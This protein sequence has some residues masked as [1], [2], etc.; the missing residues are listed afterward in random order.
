MVWCL[1]EEL[2]GT[3]VKAGTINPGS[4]ST[5]WFDGKEVDRSKML[6]AEDVARAVRLIID[7]DSTSNIDHILLLPGKR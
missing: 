4:V 1:R 2:R 7:Q 5:P 6:T 3:M